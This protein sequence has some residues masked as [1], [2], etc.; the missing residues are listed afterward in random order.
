MK[1]DAEKKIENRVKLEMLEIQID[2]TIAHMAWLM[3]RRSAILSCSE[4]QAQAAR[5]LKVAEPSPD[6]GALDSSEDE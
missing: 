5:S 6:R 4:G 3:S 2:S 1:D